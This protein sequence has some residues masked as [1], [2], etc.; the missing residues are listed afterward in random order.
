M[1]TEQGKGG[2]TNE[3]LIQTMNTGRRVLNLLQLDF[4]LISNHDMDPGLEAVG[5]DEANGW[6]TIELIASSATRTETASSLS[7]RL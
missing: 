6:S 3:D 7:H 2:G 5:E 4:D 1:K